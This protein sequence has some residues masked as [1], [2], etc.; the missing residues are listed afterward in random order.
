MH[1]RHFLL[2]AAF[3]LAGVSALLI[4]MLAATCSGNSDM[5]TTGQIAPQPGPLFLQVPCQSQQRPELV[6]LDAFD[7]GEVL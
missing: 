5:A 3:P 7:V 1:F 6:G 4:F 2:P